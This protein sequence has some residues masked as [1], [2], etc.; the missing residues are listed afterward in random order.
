MLRSE[1]LVN[2]VF[3][4]SYLEESANIGHEVINLFKDDKGRSF[5]NIPKNQ[6]IG[7]RD[8]RYVFFVTHVKSRK[9][10]EVLAVASDLAEP[11][12][13]ELEEI[14]YGGASMPQIFSDIPSDN[15]QRL[16]DFVPYKAGWV[17]VPRHPIFLTVDDSFELPETPAAGTA[18]AE[19]VR[20]KTK[21]DITNTSLRKYYSEEADR[22]VY[23]QLKLLAE[24][25]DWS[26]VKDKVTANGTSRSAGAS[27]L[28]AIRKENDELVF[29]NL[30]AYFFEYDGELLRDFCRE[31]LRIDGMD[32][33]TSVRREFKNIDIWVESGRHAVVIENKIKSGI[34]GIVSIES[35]KG[36]SQLTKYRRIAEEEAP[37]KDRRFFLLVPDYNNINVSLYDSPPTPEDEYSVLRYSNVLDFFVRHAPAYIADRCFPDFVRGL[38][39]HAVKSMPEFRLKTMKSRFMRRIA[40]VR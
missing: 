29:S 17:A 36:E 39:R 40:Q 35:D 10:V 9:T 25:N 2:Q 27:F 1:I 23:E 31:V 15:L 14:R 19:L 33:V 20:L 37:G 30:L 8:I 34:N 21:Q 26:A 12:D 4:G 18:G 24:R 16:R 32:P 6:N 7:G 13:D 3:S 5:L 38:E 11:T 28:E 22:E